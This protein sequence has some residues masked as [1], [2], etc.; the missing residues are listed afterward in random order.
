MNIIKLSAINSTNDYLKI[1]VQQQH[2][3]EYQIVWAENQ[4]SG[5]GQMGTEWCVDS[6]KNLTVSVLLKFYSVNIEQ[7]FGLNI[8]VALSVA[9]TLDFFKVSNVTLK[10]PND[11]MSDNRKL[12]GILIENIFKST[13]DVISISGIGL[14]VN[15]VEFSANYKA[16]SMSAVVGKE[17][18]RDEILIKL[19]E[20]LKCYVFRV[21]NSE[22]ELLWKEYHDRLF[23]KDVA[24]MFELP[25]GKQFSGVI[26]GVTS[27][28][29]LE[30]EDESDTILQFGIK[31]IK[32]LY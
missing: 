12:A 13:G 20:H 7:L 23:K 6:G 22:Y 17:F 32:L 28:G 16:T 8:A 11:I 31:E 21:K 5:K 24:M 14:N 30:V 1:L 18:N 2:I 29:K 19:I 10:W 26:K 25:S 27:Q 15:Q 4:T 3:E 9:Q